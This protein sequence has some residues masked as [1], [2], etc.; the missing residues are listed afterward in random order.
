[1]RNH[2]WGSMFLLD[3]VS[4]RS[5]TCTH[6]ATPVKPAQNSAP[7]C[8]IRE[9]LK[10]IDDRGELLDQ[11]KKRIKSGYYNKESVIEDIGYGFAQALDASL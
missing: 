6:S 11:I 10:Q 9:S 8:A 5:A 4:D 1:M 2:G 3:S 7:P